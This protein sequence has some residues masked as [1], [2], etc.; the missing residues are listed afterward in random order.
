[1]DRRGGRRTCGY[2][3]TIGRSTRAWRIFQRS[4]RPRQRWV[5]VRGLEAQ[6]TRAM[7]SRER[8]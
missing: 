4:P 1:M 2:W 6:L 3:F 8:A 7:H 5:V